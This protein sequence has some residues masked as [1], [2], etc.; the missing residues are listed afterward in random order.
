MDATSAGP[1]AETRVDDRE[2][3]RACRGVERD[4]PGDP[5][6]AREMGAREARIDANE[7]IAVG[8]TNGRPAGTRLGKCGERATSMHEKC[9]DEK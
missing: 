3:P 6:D 9:V 5:R 8:G 4:A 7:D 2:G 1:V